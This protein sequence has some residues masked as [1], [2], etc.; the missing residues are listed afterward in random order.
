MHSFL[1]RHCYFPSDQILYI[2]SILKFED[3]MSSTKDWVVLFF[4]VSKHLF[5]YI[6]LNYCLCAQ[7]CLTVCNPMD[8]SPPVPSVHGIIQARILEWIAISY[9]RGSSRPRDQ[10]HI[11]LL[12]WQARSLPLSHLSYTLL[13]NLMMFG[14]ITF[15]L[16]FRVRLTTQ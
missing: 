1:K 12:L 2:V 9:S 7:S 11:C 16:S 6:L 8:C 4:W 13:N 3:F 14:Q 5:Y 15:K 10:I